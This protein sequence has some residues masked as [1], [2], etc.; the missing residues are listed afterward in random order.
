LVL[1]YECIC[2]EGEE[3]MKKIAAFLVVFLFIVGCAPSPEFMKKSLSETL[4]AMPTINQNGNSTPVSTATPLATATPLTTATPL[5]T[6]TTEPTATQEPEYFLGDTVFQYGY[7][8]TAI[9]IQDPYVKNLPLPAGEGKKYI[10]VD[11]II[12]NISGNPLRFSSLNP[13]V[14]VKDINGYVYPQVFG[15]ANGDPTF[16]FHFIDAGEKIRQLCIFS[17][18]V[19]TQLFSLQYPLDSINGNNQ[20]IIS[21]NLRTPPEGHIPLQS[22]ISDSSS[23]LLPACRS[24]DLLYG[25]TITALKINPNA[26]PMYGLSNKAGFKFVAIQIEVENIS[27]NNKFPV[28]ESNIFLID[29]ESY[30]YPASFGIADELQNNSLLIGEKSKGWVMFRIPKTANPYCIKYG[31]DMFSD[32][33]WYIDLTQ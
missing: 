1:P 19:D 4:T 17:V 32:K 6:D 30:I 21:T 29:D 25:G 9:S 22:P 26:I 16:F 5:P 24:T 2:V 20:G 8:L 31:E 14:Q 27:N 10:A 3:I 23:T 28:D 12:S 33:Y 7:G 13:N 15:G 18:P 11:I